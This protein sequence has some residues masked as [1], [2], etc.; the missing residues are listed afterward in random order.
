[1]EEGINKEDRVIKPMIHIISES[2]ELR[3]R[4]FRLPD[5]IRKN[6][7]NILNNYKGDKGQKG[8]KRLNNLLNGDSISYLE[9]KRLKNFFDNY[10]G[11]PKSTEFILN[12]GEPM[13]LWVNN[14]LYTATK[15][16]RDYK[17]A[18]KSAGIKN[19]FIRAH[20]KE[21]QIRKNKP[22]QVKFQTNN[23]SGNIYNDAFAKYEAKS[24]KRYGK[25]I[26]EPINVCIT[27][28]QFKYYIEKYLL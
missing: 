5:G 1:M 20:N 11:S 19:A 27:E 28:Q 6:L 13:K 24:H 15:S 7:Q 9:M 3:N 23:A 21:R 18:M 8:Y 26:D 25:G 22:T 17:Y 12:G 16:I 14:T 4:V 2:N 10:Q